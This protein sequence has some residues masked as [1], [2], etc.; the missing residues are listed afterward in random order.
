[1]EWLPWI[2]ILLHG[3]FCYYM[4]CCAGH[5]DNDDLSEEAQIE[6]K[7]YYWDHPINGKSEDDWQ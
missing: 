7:K 2:V 6:L 3:I 5:G 4:G 1:M